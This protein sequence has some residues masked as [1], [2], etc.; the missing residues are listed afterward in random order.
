MISYVFLQ[1]CCILLVLLLGALS[2]TLLFVQGANS[3]LGSLGGDAK[4]RRVIIHSTRPKWKF[5]FISLVLFWG[6]S[7]AILYFL[8]P[9]D[10]NKLWMSLYG[11]YGLWMALFIFSVLQTVLYV[12]QSIL[13]R[14]LKSRPFHLFF[15]M[16]GM[17]IPFLFGSI[18]GTF[19]EHKHFPRWSI[20]DTDGLDALLDP[21]VL[22]FGFTVFFLAR[23]LGTLYV[24]RNV[25]D[26]DIRSRAR[27]RL[28]G[29]A[30]AFTGLFGVYLI[31]LLINSF[32]E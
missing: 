31:H 14:V 29:S 8:S 30:I 23:V 3:L 1:T 10:Y 17:A 5:T 25:D 27:V 4:G 26:A 19:L 18:L 21:W 7:Q 32:S 24:L 13:S 15:V 22:F 9:N 20:F 28:T 12:F 2:V 6:A 11:P 16:T